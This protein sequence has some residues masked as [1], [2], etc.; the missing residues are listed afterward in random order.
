M[1]SQ[2]AERC[3]E[4]KVEDS[5]EVSSEVERVKKKMNELSGEQ[6]SFWNFLRENI[7]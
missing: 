7:Y 1:V 5:G 2:T 6:V 4:A 3:I